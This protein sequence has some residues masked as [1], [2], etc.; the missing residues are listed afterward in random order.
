M[1]RLKTIAMYV[2]AALIS[3]GF[4]VLLGILMFVQIPE[5]NKEILY[6]AIGTELAGVSTIVGY[7]YGSSIGSKEKTELLGKKE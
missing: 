5:A 4:F 2:L 6:L 7:F 1:D 3:V